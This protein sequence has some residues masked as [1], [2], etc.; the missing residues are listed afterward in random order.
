MKN[1]R[2][3]KFSELNSCIRYGFPDFGYI[4]KTFPGRLD[5]ISPEEVFQEMSERKCLKDQMDLYYE[6]KSYY[7]TMRLMP[8]LAKKVTVESGTTLLSMIGG[9]FCKRDKHIQ[10]SVEEDITKEEMSDSPQNIDYDDHFLGKGYRDLLGERTACVISV[11]HMTRAEA[12]YVPCDHCN[13]SGFVK[14]PACNGTGREQYSDGYYASGEERVRT[15]ACSECHGRGKVECPECFGKGEVEIFAKEYSVL[16]SVEEQ[17]FQEVWGS[18]NT[19]W[20]NPDWLD[21]V[22]YDPDEQ[23]E[24]NEDDD[25]DMTPLDRVYA[26]ILQNG[27]AEKAQLLNKAENVVILKKN[28]REMAIDRS[29][30]VLETMDSLG[31][32][33]AYQENLSRYSNL[34]KDLKY[35]EICRQELHYVFPATRINFTLKDRSMTAYLFQENENTL[36]CMMSQSC[37]STSV[38]VY[39]C[40]RLADFVKWIVKRFKK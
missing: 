29:K 38:F 12:P 23:E 35:P 10:T 30:E 24:E 9:V 6:G 33:E 25:S 39:L 18:W 19:P 32:G 34:V 14:C 15:T 28:R 13:G 4:K 5:S 2:K 1:I 11:K 16:K 27:E 26:R 20:K 17:M 36:S 7:R 22:F 8:R 3:I 37:E 40:Y 21:S 31:F